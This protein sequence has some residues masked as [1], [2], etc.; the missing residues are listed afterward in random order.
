MKSPA[1]KPSQPSVLSISN[2]PPSRANST[3]PANVAL[4]R[5]IVSVDE[6][7]WRSGSPFSRNDGSS[8]APS[9]RSMLVAGSKSVPVPVRA[10]ELFTLKEPISIQASPVNLLAAVSVTSS[11]SSPGLIRSK[12][13]SVIA[14][15]SKGFP[16][17]A[18]ASMASDAPMKSPIVD[19]PPKVFAADTYD[20]AP[21]RRS[22]M[23]KA[24]DSRNLDTAS[25]GWKATFSLL[26]AA[27]TKSRM[28]ATSSN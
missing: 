21:K 15:R 18:S 10:A 13:N 27:P 7:N 14:S 22:R 26:T 2:K 20:S 16:P 11:N 24:S 19:F 9:L 17:S 23:G 5:D 4:E 6:S 3:F 12:M 25:R 1:E 28:N 8:I